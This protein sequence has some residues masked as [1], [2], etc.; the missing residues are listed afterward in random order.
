MRFKWEQTCPFSSQSRARKQPMACARFAGLVRWC[1]ALGTNIPEFNLCAS[2]ETTLKKFKTRGRCYNLSAVL[3]SSAILFCCCLCSC[4]SIP[5]KVKFCW[6]I[7]ERVDSLHEYVASRWKLTNLTE[8]KTVN[9]ATQR[10]Q[11]AQQNT[12]N[13]SEPLARY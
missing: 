1:L 13:Q 11:L 5:T 3:L 2:L 9:N 8:E 7:G 4:C 10:K 12:C 6:L